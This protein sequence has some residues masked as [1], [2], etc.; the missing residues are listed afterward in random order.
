MSK[1]VSYTCHEEVMAEPM[2][3]GA[4][5]KL[6]RKPVDGPLQDL[7]YRVVYADGYEH[8]SPKVDFEE[9]YTANEVVEEVEPELNLEP[10]PVVD[11]V[12][13]TVKKGKKGNGKG[14]KKPDTVST[15]PAV[16]D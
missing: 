2:S 3:R 16:E 9:G 12:E 1:L 15:E 11:V 10:E 14:K 7:G 13:P 5:V 4:F 8:W 6:S